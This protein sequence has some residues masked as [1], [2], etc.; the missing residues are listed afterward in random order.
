M[1]SLGAIPEA[2][3]RATKGRTVLL[4]VMLLLHVPCYRGKHRNDIG[5]RHANRFQRANLGPAHCVRQPDPHRHRRRGA[6]LRLRDD[7]RPH[8]G[9]AQSGIQIPLHQHRGIPRRHAGGL[10][11]TIGHHRV[12]RRADQE[13][14][15]RA[16]GHGGTAPARRADRKNIGHHRLSVERPADARYRRRLVPGG[17]RGDRRGAVRG[18]RI[19]DRRVDGRLPGI[20]DRRAAEI[21]GNIRKFRRRRVYAEAGA[22]SDPD[23][24]RRRE[25]AGAAPHGKIRPR[26]VSG[27]YQPAIPDEHGRAASRPAW[28]ACAALPKK[29]GATRRR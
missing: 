27:G 17:I 28:R 3:R 8:H 26:L 15:L 29:P 21:L 1:H 10:A 4:P 22:E 9:P 2:V 24:G 11:R 20:V 5:G 25:R 6:R 18:S 23:L 19:R 14:A 7:Q 12:Y 13:A 16:V